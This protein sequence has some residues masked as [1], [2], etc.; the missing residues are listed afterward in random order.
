MKEKISKTVKEIL[1]AL[2]YHSEDQALL[3]IAL[4]S[5]SGKYAEF[6]EECKRL[7]KKYCMSFKDFQKKVAQKEGEDF[8]AEDDLMAWKFAIEGR[9]YW[10]DKIKGVKDA[11][12]PA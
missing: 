12:Q 7:E 8:K 4:L 10:K 6:V 5:A 2:N 1:D 3:D 9:D 11:L